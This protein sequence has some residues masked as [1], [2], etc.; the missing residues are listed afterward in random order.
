MQ[1]PI[2]ASQ[3]PHGT[4]APAVSCFARVCAELWRA[5]TIG[6]RRWLTD[7]GPGTNLRVLSSA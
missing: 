2:P 1:H 5:Q 3:E 7:G 4:S 6:V